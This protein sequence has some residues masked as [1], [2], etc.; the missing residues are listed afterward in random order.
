MIGK[1][2]IAACVPDMS[3]PPADRARR[4]PENYTLTLARKEHLKAIPVI[5]LAAASMFAEADVPPGIRYRVTDPNVLQ[6][7]QGNRQLWVALDRDN[8]PI[9]FAMIV[10]LDGLAHL[11]ELDVHPQHMR[12]GVGS[13][14]LQATIDWATREQYVAMTLVTFRHLAWNAPFYERFGFF[15]IQQEALSSNLRELFSDEAAAGLMMQN[16]VAMR[17][18]LAI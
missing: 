17:R 13:S 14:L 2:Q 7:A 6:E 16:R 5:E 18:S 4:M 10:I 3:L 8:Q 11:D 12:L 1:W 15:E 9:G